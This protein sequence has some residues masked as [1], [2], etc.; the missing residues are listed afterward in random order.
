MRSANVFSGKITNWDLLNTNLRPYL[1]E[2]PYLRAIQAE[3]EP[4]SDG[5]EDVALSAEL[6]DIA[7]AAAPE[8]E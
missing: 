7:P 1:E 4:P 8:A 5:L 3:L 2:M 6:G